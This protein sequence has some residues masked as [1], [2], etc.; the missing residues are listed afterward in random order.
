M[1]STPVA[2]SV[3]ILKAAL[4]NLQLSLIRPSYKA[5]AMFLKTDQTANLLKHRPPC[6]VGFQK[7]ATGVQKKTALKKH[8][9]V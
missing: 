4:A 2:M 1:G 9:Q 6:M 8:Q 7:Y 5:Q 3:T